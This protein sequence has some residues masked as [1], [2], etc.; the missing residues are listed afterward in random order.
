MKNQNLHLVKICGLYTAQEDILGHYYLV[1]YLLRRKA[2]DGQAFISLLNEPTPRLIQVPVDME[3][4][5]RHQ[6]WILIAQRMTINSPAI[7]SPES[8]HMTR[9]TRSKR[10]VHYSQRQGLLDLESRGQTVR[11]KFDQIQIGPRAHH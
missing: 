4:S 5:S 2:I 9:Y 8:T 7:D 6:F 3:E 11:A 1:Q 10:L